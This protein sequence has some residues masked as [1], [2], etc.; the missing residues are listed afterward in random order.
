MNSFLSQGGASA[1]DIVAFHGYRNQKA[2]DIVSLVYH[3]KK[4]MADNGVSKLPLWDTEANNKMAQSPE[5]QAAFMA[6]YFLLQWSKGV[7]RFLWYAYDGD[8]QWGRLFNPYNNQPLSVSR[9]YVEVYNWM[10]GATLVK[11]CSA[12]TNGNW[13]CLF[14]RGGKQSEAIWNSTS[15]TSVPVPSQFSKYRDLFGGTH[16]ISAGT[17]EVGNQPILLTN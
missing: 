15:T 13:S 9:T 3:Y 2:E 12:D 5:E 6:K 7:S 17:V 1:I 16:A 14:S 10:V 8:P 4:M 11:A